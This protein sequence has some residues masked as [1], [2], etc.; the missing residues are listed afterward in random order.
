MFVCTAAPRYRKH[1]HR[2]QKQQ[3]PHRVGTASPWALLW[4]ADWYPLSFSLV[5]PRF[6]LHISLIMSHS[7]HSGWRR[8]QSEVAPHRLLLLL[9]INLGRDFL[10]RGS[11]LAQVVLH[12]IMPGRWLAIRQGLVVAIPNLVARLEAARHQSLTSLPTRPLSRVLKGAL[13]RPTTH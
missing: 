1:G 13:E 6:N 10:V 9:F 7:W 8:S 4:Q 12:P 2:H 11:A 5:Q 3:K